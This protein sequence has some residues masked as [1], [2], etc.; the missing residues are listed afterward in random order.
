MNLCKY[1]SEYLINDDILAVFFN[2]F[3]VSKSPLHVPSLKLLKQLKLHTPEV[4]SKIIA[5]CLNG[6]IKATDISLLRK[7]ALQ[8][9]KTFEN[10]NVEMWLFEALSYALD[11]VN[12]SVQTDVCDELH[13]QFTFV[14]IYG[15]EKFTKAKDQT[16]IITKLMVKLI[17]LIDKSSE[18]SISNLYPLIDIIGLF[19][20]EIDLHIKLWNL[21]L[22]KLVKIVMDEDR[23]NLACK[24]LAHL[25]I[26]AVSN[27]SKPVVIEELNKMIKK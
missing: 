20:E 25:C 2:I 3:N 1:C 5:R 7:E 12:P 21:I 16:N 18:T 14:K 26:I 27:S 8:L 19:P 17:N 10:H 9:L 22:E 15:I 23:E 24:E 6:K 13:R 4:V 11:D